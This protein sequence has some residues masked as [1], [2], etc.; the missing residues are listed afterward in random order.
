MT[1]DIIIG[2]SKLDTEKL[3][4]VGTVLL[5]KQY[6]R[7]G[8]VETLA[9]SLYLDVARSHVVFIAGKRG[10][11][12][13]L[14]P[15]S[16][17]IL[18]DSSLKT[19]KEIF[20][21]IKITGNTVKN[22]EDEEIIENTQNIKV[23]SLSKDTKYTVSRISH[24][25]R[26][27]INEDAIEITT[28]T[29]KKIIVTKEH[30]LLRYDKDNSYSWIEAGKLK[31]DDRIALPRKLNILPN[32]S[33]II[34]YID[35]R[36]VSKN[37]LGKRFEF[38]ELNAL[39][40][41]MIKEGYL[42]EYNDKGTYY[43]LTQ[44]AYT[45]LHKTKSEITTYA[46][47]V[48]L[49]YLRT[50]FDSSAEVSDTEI[51]LPIDD[52]ESRDKIH[53]A[54]LRFGVVSE[55]SDTAIRIK[56]ETS[57]ANFYSYI[58]FNSQYK[59]SKLLDICKKIK[60]VT[61]S[62]I[63]F[64]AVTEIK[65]KYYY[66]WVYDLTIED[67]HNFIANG[68]ISHNSYTMGAIAEGLADL[69]KGV[70][71]NI[72]MIMLDTMGIYWTMKYPN[73]QDIELL[74]EWGLE[75]KG[76]KNIEIFTPA[77]FFEK[78]RE[79]G[80]PTDHPFSIRPSDFSASDWCM[81]FSIDR[82]SE[83]GVVIEKAIMTIKDKKEKYSIKDI[84]NSITEEQNIQNHIK[85]ASI[86][87]FL[88]A[89]SWGIFSEDGTSIT[90]LVK[91][92]VV[93]V[94]D[95]SAYA[96]M[97]DGWAVKALVVGIIAQKLFIERMLARKYEELKGIESSLHYFGEEEQEE[98]K[99]KERKMPLVWLVIDESH[100]F[101]PNEGKTTATDSL[102]TI[103]REGRQPGISLILATQQP[104]KIH[105]DVMTQADI[106]FSHRLTAQLDI[107][108]LGNLLQSYM[109]TGLDE[110]LNRLP[111]VSGSGIIIDDQNERMYLVRSRPRMTWHGGGSPS[112]FKT[113]KKEFEF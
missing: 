57:L 95:V 67:T 43:S 16:K 75:S 74:K 107:K 63:Y 106:I 110:L 71:E 103:L 28:K 40:S 78:Y 4:K 77:G 104:G 36:Y 52:L 88:V 35:N 13:C 33:Q 65:K 56:D 111:R 19:I 83:V 48:I 17:I 69:P 64:D 3:G 96:T 2:R 92:G 50:V 112:L 70:S 105:T 72:S 85:D 66:G 100:E 108:A 97:P 79:D 20:D 80:I 113:E 53:I 98:N 44:K 42:D 51:K 32:K 89:D 21:S 94:L 15:D 81:T 73:H 29:N 102:I 99:M 68:I 26:K 7:M 90:E 5:A 18:D 45:V 30:P 22:E 24:A 38:P 49:K 60:S 84:I 8:Q 10:S 59:A 37:E 91:P 62:D 1:Q 76:L 9:N 12:K 86:N 46:I 82:N 109:Q 11:G 55:F 58:G 34:N 6:V 31:E 87:R 27:K 23:V 25:Y 93:T 41:G 39:L 14:S 101:L 47:D 61:D 54:L